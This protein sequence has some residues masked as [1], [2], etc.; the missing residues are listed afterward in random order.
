MLLF[1]EVTETACDAE[2]VPILLRW[3]EARHLTSIPLILSH[4]LTGQESGSSLMG[5]W[6]T[7]QQIAILS[8]SSLHRLKIEK[9]AGKP[10]VLI[11]NC[12]RRFQFFIYP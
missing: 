3:P 7:G 12:Q 10:Q 5:M 8:D 9:E 6:G 11:K 4:W 2:T 1:L